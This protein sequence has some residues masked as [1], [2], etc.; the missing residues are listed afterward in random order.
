MGKV[1]RKGNLVIRMEGSPFLRWHTELPLDRGNPLPGVHPKEL[2][3]LPAVLP[4][5]FI[6]EIVPSPMRWLGTLV[7]YH[8]LCILGLLFGFSVT[9]I[10]VSA[11]LPVPCWFNCYNFVAGGMHHVESNKLVLKRKY[12]MFSLTCDRSFLKIKI[13]KQQKKK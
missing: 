13:K 2:N 1:W 10:C 8:W 3:S 12:C 4:A 5:P 11:F 9:L 7:K 6:E